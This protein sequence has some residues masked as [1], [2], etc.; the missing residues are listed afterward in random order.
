[1]A[2]KFERC[3]ESVKARGGARSPRGVCATAGRR[4]YGAKRFQAMARAGRSNPAESA[5]Q[6]GL[7]EAVLAGTSNV[8]PVSVAREMIDATPKT[9]RSKFARELAAKHRSNKSRKNL[10]PLDFGTASL[11]GQALT[12][13]EKQREKLAK[14]LKSNKSKFRTRVSKLFG[15][16]TTFHGKVKRTG[17]KVRVSKRRGNPANPVGT[18]REAYQRFHGRPSEML[19]EVRT[20]IHEHTVLAAIGDLVKLKIKPAAG[21][22]AVK[23]QKFGTN[24]DGQKALL[25]MN[26]GMSQMFIE[27]GD[28]SVD[29]D[30]FGVEPPFREFETL[31]KL[32]DVWYFTTKDHLRPEDGGT[33]N[34]HHEFGVKY[35]SKGR[36]LPRDL[37]ACPDVLYDVRNH[38]LSFSGGR[39]TI[40]DEGIDG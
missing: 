25:C 1:M 24:K 13:I 22:G 38:L 7:A 31:G 16:K 27:G 8:M 19:V 20:P 33:A 29:L 32:T 2:S 40:P 36:R 21:G 9:L 5:A 39:Y 15:K 3:V 11:T 14:K 18:A 10:L 30:A 23:L 12:A 37:K 17:A 6:F 28:Q 4:K 34:Y 26:E 35:D